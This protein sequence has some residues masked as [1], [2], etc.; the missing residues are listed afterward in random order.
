MAG[1]KKARYHVGRRDGVSHQTCVES[2]RRELFFVVV[3][4]GLCGFVCCT[5]GER[6]ARSILVCN[7]PYFRTYCLTKVLCI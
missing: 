3:H 2:P 5:E 1:V 4:R 7:L 6:K